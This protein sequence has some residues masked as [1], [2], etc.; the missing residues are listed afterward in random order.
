MDKFLKAL[1]ISEHIILI[2]A[3]FVIIVLLYYRFSHKSNI[4]TNINGGTITQTTQVIKEDHMVKKLV[5][6]T[7]TNTTVISKEEKIKNKEDNNGNGSKL[8][9]KLKEYLFNNQDFEKCIKDNDIDYCRKAISDISNV[10]N[11]DLHLKSKN[12]KTDVY[13]VL[14]ENTTAVTTLIP[15]EYIPLRDRLF[16]IDPYLNIGSDFSSFISDIGIQ[17]ELVNLNKLIK[18]PIGL[19]SGISYD[20]KRKAPELDLGIN[21]NIDPS[22]LNV[23]LF[24]GVEPNYKKVYLAIGVYLF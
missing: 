24:Y 1:Q 20:I 4:N 19:S 7:N 9:A 22:T 10:Y 5:N 18:V 23:G 2:I 21:Y 8:T 16:P 17:V 15:E 12:C 6:N 11:F 14:G 3:I 13:N